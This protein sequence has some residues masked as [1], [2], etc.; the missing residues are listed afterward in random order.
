MLE[1]WVLLEFLQFLRGAIQGLV[2]T[3]PQAVSRQVAGLALVQRLAQDGDPGAAKAKPQVG[4][5][6][7]APGVLIEQALVQCVQRQGRLRPF[8]ETEVA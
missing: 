1:P 2:L 5:S 6:R 7:S 4:K 8:I 3:A